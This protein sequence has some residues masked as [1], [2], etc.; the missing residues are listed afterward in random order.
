MVGATRSMKIERLAAEIV[1]SLIILV[2]AFNIIGSLIML[3][4]EKR[5]EIGI[6][7]SI[8]AKSASIMKIFIYKGGIIASIGI[9]AGGFTGF[10]LCWLQEKF[11]FVPLPTDTYVIDYLP[12]DVQI[13]D[14]ISVLLIAVIICFSSTVY[15]AWKAAQLNPVEAIRYE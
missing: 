7:K 15:P 12:V 4:L 13:A 1:L 5:R 6:L 14:M 2:A 8:G 10:F 11:R 3:V 9:I